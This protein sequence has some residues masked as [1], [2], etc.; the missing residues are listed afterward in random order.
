MN[1]IAC[2]IAHLIGV[3]M[4]MSSFALLYQRRLTAVV[5]IFIVQAATLTAAAAWQAHI[6]GDSID[7]YT[8]AAGIL[9][10]KVVFVPI[11]LCWM[12]RRYGGAQKIVEVTL[13]VRKSMVL[14]VALV[15]LSIFLAQ[16][17][18]VDA[19]SLTH[20]TQALVLSMILLG[21]L[22]MI[23]RR[24]L[25]MQAVAFMMLENGLQLAAV[26]AEGIPFVMA[27]SVAFSMMIAIM[28]FGFFYF[29]GGVLLLTLLA[30]AFHYVSRS[31]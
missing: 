23:T 11:A 28:A 4:L 9:V 24:N 12:I 2:N 13:G 18:T 10:F 29:I 19:G 14:G 30:T 20:A 25:I 1:L 16:P 5:S 15:G 27:V 21:F 31:A 26:S 6:R 7:L 8:T 17:V 3:V 22:T